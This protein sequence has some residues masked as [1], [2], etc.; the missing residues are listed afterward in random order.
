MNTAQDLKEILRRI[1][2]R[3]YPAYKDTRGTYAFVDP[4]ATNAARS[5]TFSWSRMA[6]WS[7]ASCQ[8]SCREVAGRGWTQCA[9]CEH[10][11]VHNQSAQWQ[12]YG[13]VHPRK[14]GSIGHKRRQVQ[15]LQLVADGRLGGRGRRGS[16][17]KTGSCGF[18][19]RHCIARAGRGKGRAEMLSKRFRQNPAALHKRYD[20][21]NRKAFTKPR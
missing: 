15:D 13:G 1:E 5:R 7:M 9:G 19:A 14:D 12:G 20:A 2:G 21:G 18:S 16:R 11:G 8:V 17:R 6:V 3:P 4:S 10:F